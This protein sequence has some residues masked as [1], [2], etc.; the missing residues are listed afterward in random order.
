MVKETEYYDVLG[1]NY[2]ASA[3]EIKKAY[4]IKARVVHPDKNP[5]DPKAAHNFQVLGEAYQVLSDPV[6]R[7]AYDKDGKAGVS[8]DTMEDPSAVFGMLFGS[9]SF[10]DYIGQLA[11]ASIASIE[12]DGG[13]QDPIVLRKKVQE[14]IK[15]LQREREEKLAQK[16][17]DF[18][19]PFILGNKDEFV[20]WAN[21][22]AHRLSQA[23]FGEAMLHTIGYIY[24][25]QAGRELG[26]TEWVRDKGHAIKS[27]VQAAAGAVSLLQIQEEMMRMQQSEG[28]EEDLMKQIEE[29][30]D[31]M[32]TSL[33]KVNV[34]DI[35]STFHMCVLR[36]T[37]VPKD[38]LKQRARALRKLGAI[39]QG[40]KSMYRRD[41]SLRTDD[42][43]R[44]ASS[45]AADP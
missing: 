21:S 44:G 11:L 34:I 29:K 33:W 18:I 35:E 39:F 19:Q 43:T 13:P 25:R 45:S 40:A 6:K 41:R 5:G 9:D 14:K 38:V 28:T 36:D 10:E 22:E 23:S 17:K 27:Q 37:S 24:Q 32:V 1:V 2:N 42:P 15:E 12:I 26:K 3:S 7:E 20:T 8:E 30:K 31:E 16:L 4:Y